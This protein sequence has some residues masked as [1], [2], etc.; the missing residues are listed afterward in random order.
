MAEFYES[1]DAATLAYETAVAV[2]EERGREREGLLIERAELQAEV[3]RVL[4]ALAECQARGLI[5]WNK[6]DPHFG[7]RRLYYRAGN[8][9][10][11][12]AEVQTV[13]ANGQRP[14]VSLKSGL[15]LTDLPNLPP[16]DFA[17]HHEPEDD[18]LDPAQFR[19]G[20]DAAAALLPADVRPVVCLMG[21]TFDPRSGRIAADWIPETAEAIAIDPYN[22]F[23]VTGATWVSPAQMLEAPLA[24]AAS[25]SLPLLIWETN[26][27]EDPADP[28]RKATWLR[29]F[30]DLAEAE[31]IEQLVFF[32]AL[33]TQPG[34]GKFVLFSSPQA[35]AAVEEGLAR[36]YFAK[37]TP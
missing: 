6:L 35:T 24:F 31:R 13:I 37:E 14:L 34:A 11:M 28:G 2:A 15:P 16:C 18:F 19:A 22:W 33:A 4:A 27:A 1:M 9:G 17:W 30:F 8:V 32:D 20:F 29:E 26:C 7:A 12:L 10:N 23:G 3:A 25:V 21:W 36:P 5:G